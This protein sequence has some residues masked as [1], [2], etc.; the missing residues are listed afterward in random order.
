MVL[1][2]LTVL[3]WGTVPGLL[4]GLFLGLSSVAVLFS[5]WDTLAISGS[6]S[7]T[8]GLPLLTPRILSSYLLL[9]NMAMSSRPP[10]HPSHWAHLLLLLSI[11][12]IAPPR[13]WLTHG[14]FVPCEDRTQPLLPWVPFSTLDES[15]Y[16]SFRSRRKISLP[17]GFSGLQAE[18]GFKRLFRTFC[19][20]STH[21]SGSEFGPSGA[22]GWMIGGN[23]RSFAIAC[24]IGL[25]FDDLFLALT[26]PT[27]STQWY[28][29]LIAYRDSF[30]DFWMRFPKSHTKC[31]TNYFDSPM[32]CVGY[33]R[34]PS[35]SDEERRR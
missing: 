26:H 16:L 10:T 35:A 11:T 34:P 25:L 28:T 29:Q 20:L 9:L 33:S 24:D 1:L 27:P 32:Q 6:L 7:L 2:L 17:D 21:R 18:N 8:C 13:A 12:L 4:V 31:C 22:W 3:C 30:F 15:A 23:I 14:L 5:G 19:I